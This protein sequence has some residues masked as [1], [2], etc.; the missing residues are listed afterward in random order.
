LYLALTK[1][2]S[3]HGPGHRIFTL[4]ATNMADAL[5]EVDGTQYNIAVVHNPMHELSRGRELTPL[6]PENNE[7]ITKPL[8]ALSPETQ[9]SSP[10]ASTT[11]ERRRRR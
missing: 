10:P 6:D 3:A 4:K 11:T 2:W 9:A 8:R 7:R 1:T 5:R